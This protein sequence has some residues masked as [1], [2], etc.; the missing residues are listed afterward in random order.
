MTAFTLQTLALLGLAYFAGCAIACMLRRMMSGA[1]VAARPVERAA[2][3]PAPVAV[4]PKPV[5]P[6][7]AAVQPAPAPGAVRPPPVLTPANV[8][9]PPV[10][11]P[12]AAPVRDAF[13]R[14]DTLEPSAKPPAAAL[15]PPAVTPRAAPPQNENV[16]RFERALAGEQ[17]RTAT[18]AQ[19]AAAPPPAQAP[20]PS[21]PATPPP[22]IVAKPAAPAAPAAPAPAPAPAA[23]AP[24][25][26]P[27]AAP[28]SVAAV[29]PPAQTAATTKP[30]DL[31][32]IRAIDAML[33]TELNRLGIRRY[34]EI[35]QWRPDDVAKVS[36]ALG[37]KGRIEQENWIE[38]AQILARGEDTFYSQRIARGEQPTAR[39]V[40][41]E[42]EKKP[43]PAAQAPIPQR[44]QASTEQAAA[45]AAAVAAAT[46]TRVSAPVA[47]PPAPAAAPQQAAQAARPAA[48]P[49]AQQQP[50][51]QQ[52]AKPMV[53]DRAAFARPATPA[54]P[55]G[56]AS[57]QAPTP[58][59]AQPASGA[60]PA[61][62]TPAMQ[63]VAAQTPAVRPAATPHATPTVVRQAP[64]QP[65][66]A[67]APPAA[68]AQPRPAAVVTPAAAP[69][70]AP[71]PVA[72]PSPVAAPPAASP[73]AAPPASAAV[74]GAVAAA[75]AAAA[76][77]RPAIGSGRDN[78]QR[79]GGISAEVEK[80]LNTQGI[81]RYSQ[82]ANWGAGDVERY[83]RLFGSQG[84]VKRENWVEQAQILAKGSDTAYSREHDRRESEAQR[85][86]ES[87]RPATL[88]E[89]VRPGA[90]AAAPPAQ[91]RTSD[92][93]SLRSVRSEGLRPAGTVAAAR[94]GQPDDLKRIRGIGVLI[95][96]KLNSMGITHY[97]QIANWSAADIDRV[98]HVLDFKGRIERENWVEQARILAAGGQTE[99]SRRADREDEPGA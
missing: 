85:N 76:G 34:A 86:A 10:P 14:A 11:Q 63:A 41:D 45:A 71:R 42:G 74:A 9:R 93:A 60:P 1:T 89:A 3:A 64:A 13:R 27:A 37:F 61:Q 48:P 32:R 73:P 26:P 88:T 15:V 94:T 18:P 62:R 83:D 2:V 75:A 43:A 97:D 79:I 30:D 20:R 8:Q 51:P 6:A 38:Q 72:P 7:P 44:P 91:P 36:Q 70:A 49:P 46:A 4:A 16:T 77:A 96:K 5:A 57:G 99:F 28:R 21:P 95:E 24:A 54:A 56:Q 98:S 40:T 84:R 81:T 55:Q 35:A 23:A 65:A 66:P 25:A 67:A 90:P 31:K 22:V 39:P 68:P 80:L 29:T 12:V 53:E 33:E 52:P 58:S 69:P 59:P 87:A 47:P 19:V 50:A 78:L 17:T 92:M 82:I